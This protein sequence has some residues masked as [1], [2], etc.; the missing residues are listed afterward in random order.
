MNNQ[1]GKE[2]DTLLDDLIAQAPRESREMAILVRLAMLDLHPDQC[3]ELRIHA[4]EDESYVSAVQSATNAF[5]VGMGLY[6]SSIAVHSSVAQLF[7]LEGRVFKAEHKVEGIGEFL[8][9]KGFQATPIPVEADDAL[10]TRTVAVRFK[11]D[12]DFVPVVKEVMMQ[13]IRAKRAEKDEAP[14]E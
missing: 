9:G 7:A 8:L 14:N 2:M 12:F 13:R 3:I 5:L 10:D 4:Y 11:I 1:A 6:P